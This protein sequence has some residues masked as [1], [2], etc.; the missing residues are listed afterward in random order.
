MKKLF[1]I[2]LLLPS[3]LMSCQLYEEPEITSDG[4]LGID[5]TEVNI[6]ANIRL[7]LRVSEFEKTQTRADE[8]GNYRHRIIVEA[9]QNRLQAARKIVY[10][11]ISDSGQLDI[12][13]GMKLHARNYQLVV[14]ADYVTTDSE[15]D[16][17]YDTRDLVSAVSTEPYRANTDQKDVFCTSQALDLSEYRNQWSIKVPLQ[18]ELERPVARYELITNDIERFRNKIVSQYGEAATKKKFTLTVRYTDYQPIGYNVLDKVT[19]HAMMY[20]NYSKSISFPEEGVEKMQIA[21]DY[22]FVTGGEAEIPVAVELTNDANEVIARTYLRIP[23]KKGKL[24]TVQGN[25]LTNLSNGGIQVDSEFEG[26]INTD[27][28]I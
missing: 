27:I 28:I 6:E 15:K 20:M 13:V 17:Y 7:N 10:E 25:F 26:E 16:L 21:F 12:N 5:P 8:S 23:C 22:P 9:Y 2:F 4:E 24:T 19:K 3:L 18:I 11:P 1:I 14:W